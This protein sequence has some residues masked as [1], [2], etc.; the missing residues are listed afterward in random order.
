M[1]SARF[2]TVAILWGLAAAASAQ[3]AVAPTP[4]PEPRATR[5]KPS[6]VDPCAV[7]VELDDTGVADWDFVNARN[8]PYVFTELE[9]ALDGSG[10]AARQDAL[11]R[12][13]QVLDDASRPSSGPDAALVQKALAARASAGPPNASAQRLTQC[14]HRM[15]LVFVNH[16]S[17]QD[18]VVKFQ[19]AVAATGGCPA[20]WKLS[21]DKKSCATSARVSRDGG[22]RA[23]SLVQLA[24]IY[25]LTPAWFEEE[26]QKALTS[27]PAPGSSRLPF[28]TNVE[29][30]AV[31]FTVEF[32]AS[33]D[34]PAHPRGY[35]AV[36]PYH[37]E[38]AST[39][40]LTTKIVTQWA[41]K[42]ALPRDGEALVTASQPYDGADLGS[43]PAA[44]TVT[45]AQTLGDRAVA[46]VAL[47]FR[48][49][50]YNTASNLEVKAAQYKLGVSSQ[51]GIQLGVGRF[52]F[53]APSDGIAIDETGDG[54][55]LGFRA[56]GLSHLIKR[57]SADGT[58]DARNEDH[59]PWLLTLDNLGLPRSTGLRSLSLVALHGRE[60]HPL[61]DADGDGASDA[62][63]AFPHRY[64]TVGGSLDFGLPK[65][66]IGGSIGLYKSRR[67][68]TAGAPDASGTVWLFKASRAFG[69]PPADDPSSSFEP[70]GSISVSVGRGSG[71]RPETARDEGYMGETASFEPGALFV[72][73][74]AAR[75]APTAGVPGR[76]LPPGLSNKTYLGIAAETRRKRRSLLRLLAEPLR[77]SDDDIASGST[78]VE[79]HQFRFNTPV[80]GSRAA[81]GELVVSTD[82]ETPAGVVVSLAYARF[83]AAG[84]LEPLFEREPWSLVAAITVSLP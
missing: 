75:I 22:E 70:V 54:V 56:L 19:L 29:V 83:F 26:K 37:A 53:A 59:A 25:G 23:F 38:P 69:P 34:P 66:G 39:S 24:R 18:L 27:A 84:R 3:P 63:K 36:W 31:P 78:R 6:A 30:P 57:E 81:G 47:Q 77:I 1:T 15:S 64:R 4:P 61:V 42:P 7:V 51:S 16:S 17:S 13:L 40:K 55:R 76:A 49:G 21:D 20:P 9:L 44:G 67:W 46:S 32:F 60:R 74:L 5:L 14:G 82:L 62:G 28:P 45:L 10:A 72:P 2:L 41:R 8:P 80:D 58:P 50:V 52:Q 12:L 33:A 48:K 43:F 35:L 11:Q 73:T 68:R 71:D 65:A 79:W